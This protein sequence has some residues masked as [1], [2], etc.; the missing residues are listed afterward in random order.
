[1]VVGTERGGFHIAMG[2]GG[3]NVGLSSIQRAKPLQ[4]YPNP[5]TGMVAFNGIQ[6]QSATLTL[7]NVH[8]QEVFNQRINP[9]NK[10]D[11]SMLTEGIY[12]VQLYTDKQSSVGKL[13]KLN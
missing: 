9:Q 12:I 11:L 4:V 6:E 7:I 13:I 3:C 5:T 1:M 8:G 10:V 2:A